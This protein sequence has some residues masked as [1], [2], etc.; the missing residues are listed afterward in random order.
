MI[1]GASVPPPDHDV[2]QNCHTVLPYLQS[3]RHSIVRLVRCVAIPQVLR[4]SL[5]NLPLW[6]I[7]L[8]RKFEAMLCVNIGSSD[9]DA[10]KGRDLVWGERF[11]I[12][13]LAPSRMKPSL[14]TKTPL[15]MNLPLGKIFIPSISMRT[16]LALRCSSRETL[17]ILC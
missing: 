7:I 13:F 8:L 3:P 11:V 17:A 4:A 2:V 1:F 15:R 14:V 6:R 12:C 16:T 10:S 5:P 9:I